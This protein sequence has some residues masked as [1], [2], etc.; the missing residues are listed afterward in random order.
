MT[1]NDVAQRQMTAQPND[2]VFGRKFN[3]H[4]MIIEKQII[5]LRRIKST[6][7]PINQDYGGHSGV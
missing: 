5:F 3:I 4:I 2:A 7:V 1:I 6:F